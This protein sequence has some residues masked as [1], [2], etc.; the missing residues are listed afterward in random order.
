MKEWGPLAAAVANPHLL[1]H[2]PGSSRR[3]QPGPA[4]EQ[5]GPATPAP[6]G[7]GKRFLVAAGVFLGLT[8]AGAVA[9]ELRHGWARSH[10][11]R[12]ARAFGLTSQ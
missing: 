8:V 10:L 11:F 2:L 5:P 9:F 4:S 6:A 3:S 12:L 7:R 1:E